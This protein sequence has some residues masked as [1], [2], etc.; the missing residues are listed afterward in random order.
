MQ[1]TKLIEQLGG[2]SAV[3]R[4]FKIAQP[5][6]FGWVRR[7]KIPPSRLQTLQA[8]AKTHPGIKRALSEAG[9]STRFQK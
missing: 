5:S 9:Y 7:G 2:Q 3:S 1:I 8:L 4:L 6:V